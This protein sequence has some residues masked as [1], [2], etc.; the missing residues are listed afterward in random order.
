[1]TAE[2]FVA[3][4]LPAFQ[5]SYASSE[6]GH[7]DFW[8]GFVPEG[9]ELTIDEVI[10]WVQKKMMDQMAECDEVVAN[11]EAARKAKNAV[12]YSFLSAFGVEYAS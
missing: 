11:Q 6:Q 2:E 5:Q 9:E 8:A 12:L 10:L 7:R 4:V 1:M 3:S